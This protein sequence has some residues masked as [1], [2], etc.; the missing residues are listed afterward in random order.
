MSKVGKATLDN[1]CGKFRQMIEYKSKNKGT[2][3][4]TIN[5]FSPTTKLCHVC[6]DKYEDITLSIHPCSDLPY[7]P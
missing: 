3:F 5:R 6:C 1:S 4:V 2:Y 7:S